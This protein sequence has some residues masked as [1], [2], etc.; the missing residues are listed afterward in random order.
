MSLSLNERAKY[1]ERHLEEALAALAN[2]ANIVVV[3]WQIE[4]ALRLLKDEPTRV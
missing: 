4:D 1:A 3:Q 2:E